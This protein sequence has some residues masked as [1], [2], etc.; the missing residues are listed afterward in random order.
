MSIQTYTRRSWG[1]LGAPVDDPKILGI[2]RLT[3]LF[4]ICDMLIFISPSNLIA[5]D[6]DSIGMGQEMKIM[7]E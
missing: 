1:E 2:P 5:C 3:R 6:V 4:A 7:T